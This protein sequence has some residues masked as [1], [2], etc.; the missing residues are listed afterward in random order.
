MENF[1]IFSVIRLFRSKLESCAD[2]PIF[3]TIMTILESFHL[4]N[5]KSSLRKRLSRA[6]EADSFENYF[7]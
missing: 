1:R 7:Q 6:P 5:K 4:E 3:Q 2:T